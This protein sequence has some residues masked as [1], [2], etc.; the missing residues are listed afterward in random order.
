MA[1]WMIEVL[2]VFNNVCEATYFRAMSILDQYLKLEK[3][4]LYD[5]DIHLLGIACIFLATKIEDIYHIDMN[6]M[7][8]NVA[9]NKFSVDQ[10]KKAEWNIYTTLNFDVMFPNHF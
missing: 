8:N 3:K 9:H 6:T 5:S 1:D 4:L 7:V 2:M 10:I